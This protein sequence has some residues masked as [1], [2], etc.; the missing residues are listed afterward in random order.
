VNFMHEY[1][2]KWKPNRLLKAMR[3]YTGMAIL[4][5]ALPS[6]NANALNTP[7]WIG[8]DR[9]GIE[10]DDVEFVGY[11]ETDAGAACSPKDCY[12]AMW[13]RPGKVLLAVVNT[14]EK[15]VARLSLDANRLGLGTPGKWQVTDAEEGTSATTR[16]EK[17]VGQWLASSQEKIVHRG[18]GVLTVPVD[19]HD[20]RQVIIESRE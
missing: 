9:F 10:A 12:V 15:T 6:G 8:R 1:Q 14:G 16:S 2:G 11:W 19:R 20:Y 17:A 18:G 4:H 5:D 13:K 7:V 3:A